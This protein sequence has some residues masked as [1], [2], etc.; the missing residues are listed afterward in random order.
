MMLGLGEYHPA[1][2]PDPQ[3]LLSLQEQEVR[4]RTFLSV[5]MLL[6]R[7]E[8]A[9]SSQVSRLRLVFL[10]FFFEHKKVLNVESVSGIRGNSLECFLAIVPAFLR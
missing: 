4:R 8:V 5:I 2:D 7:Q 10:C 9:L 1:W 3:P 6:P